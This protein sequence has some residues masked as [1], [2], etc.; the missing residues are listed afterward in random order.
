MVEGNVRG[1]CPAPIS[2]ISGKFP[3]QFSTKK[4]DG[5]FAALHILM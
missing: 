3:G 2:N 4:I 1:E 5:S